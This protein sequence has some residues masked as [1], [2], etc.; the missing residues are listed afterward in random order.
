MSH[1]Y[2]FEMQKLEAISGVLFIYFFFLQS[3]LRPFTS[4]AIEQNTEGRNYFS[5]CAKD[6]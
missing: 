2:G 4:W 3:F 1:R 6:K 5:Y